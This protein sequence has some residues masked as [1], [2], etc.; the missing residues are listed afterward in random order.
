MS[1][2]VVWFKRD[3]R[4]YDH[5]AL[6]RACRGG[7]VLCLYVIEPEYWAL[8]D[9]S[10]RQW[11]FVRESLADLAQQLVDMG[12]R[13]QVVSGGV[14]DALIDLKQRHGV[15]TL[16]SHEETGNLWTYQRDLAVAAWC[17]REGCI[18]QEY[19]QN[20]VCRPVSRRRERF[21]AHW[22]RWAARP[23]F[24]VYEHAR[25]VDDHSGLEPT[26][27]PENV[28]DEDDRCDG[29]QHG[30]RHAGLA[31]LHDFLH[32]R[33]ES[34][35]G[36]IS[37]PITA[38]A[39]CSRLSPHIAYGT[40]SLREIVQRTQQAREHAASAKWSRSLAAFATR[41]EWH[42]YFMQKL[43]D[44]PDIEHNA[45]VPQMGALNRPCDRA[46][47]E[48]WQQG[49]TGWPLV[50]ACMRYLHHHGWI[51]FRMRAMLVSAAAW[52]L[53]L[54][55]RPVAEW[56]ARQF[57]DFEPGIHYP[58]I[59]M[60]SGTSAHTVLRIYNP[61]TQARNLDPDAR[62]V[63]EWVPEL[64]NVS[65]AWIFEPWLMSANLRKQARWTDEYGYPLPLVDFAQA[66]RQAKAEVAALRLAHGIQPDRPV[67]ERASTKAPVKNGVKKPKK[68][69]AKASGQLDLF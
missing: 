11:R 21:K 5:E 23:L 20:G 55:G 24:P 64:R 8:T 56:L 60:Q 40:L 29:R 65:D 18:W 6:F 47:F 59:H 43:E 13:L 33:G 61:V 19:A 68:R 32:R 48:A 38:E 2:Q 45:V 50:D 44:R 52:S 16:H 25:F 62:F 51:N 39:S 1:L 30:G 36:S 14:T 9:T 10:N 26:Q 12:G 27:W 17:R 49:R 22:Q 53:S 66:H 57:V 63:R 58:Q 54:P 37:S 28:C 3:L 42:C 46:R 67:R 31:I 35:S 41:L 4:T 34:Y 69:A 15:F 7:P